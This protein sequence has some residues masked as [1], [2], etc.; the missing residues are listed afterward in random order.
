MIIGVVGPSVNVQ[1]IEE[2]LKK[3]SLFMEAR[4]FGYQKF[5]EVPE[6]IGKHEREVD[7][8][9]FTGRI[10]Y[11]YASNFVTPQVP[12]DF[13]PRN[14]LSTLTALIKA[15][16][17]NYNIKN[18]SSDGFD[19][20]TLQLIYDEFGLDQH[21]FVFHNIN[22]DIFAP[23]YM[24]QVLSYHLD[25]IKN[26]TANSCLTGVA[27]IYE[28]LKEQNIPVI[29]I[30]PSYFLMKQ[31]IESLK[32][33]YK[34][35]QQNKK[36]F[37][38]I[39][40]QPVIFDT[41][42]E[43]PV[44]P[45]REF[46]LQTKINEALQLYAERVGAALY[47]ELNIFSLVTTREV[48]ERET[49]EFKSFDILHSVLYDNGIS[50]LAVG[51]GIGNTPYEAK[52]NARMARKKAEH[53]QAFCCYVLMATNEYIGP[54]ELSR[55]DPKVIRKNHLLQ[56][57]S[58]ISGVGLQSLERLQ[59]V[60]SEYNITQITPLELAEYCK[61]P[62]RSMN[63]ILYRLDEAGYV[64]VVGKRASIKSGRPSRVIEIHLR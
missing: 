57:I 13:L 11:T 17:N 44:N 63:R 24:Q 37:C 23:D 50:R 52:L 21:K 3:H 4:F 33:Q 39:E 10:P 42:I 26:H 19:D 61:I 51:I 2:L 38:V 15:S 60:L 54:L 12:W 16:V 49:H 48:I 40:L 46:R 30:Q 27:H 32:L 36:E 31:K 58:D 25:N 22:A 34:I 64:K 7:A 9:L 35:L 59:D 28:T 56:Q 5:T 55:M 45:L 62:F 41:N 47:T 18:I 1:F 20:T 53:K 14:L 8:I 6:L 29:K 43:K